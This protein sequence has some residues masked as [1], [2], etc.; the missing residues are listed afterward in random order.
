MPINN[1]LTP[2]R[3]LCDVRGASKKK[4]LEHIALRIS[5]EFPDVN[6]RELLCRFVHRER[7]GTTVL[8]SGIALPHCRSKCCPA[9]VGL[10]IK[11]NTPIDF[12]TTTHTLVDLVF[13]LVVPEE[14]TQNHINLLKQLVT[15]LQSQK[16]LHD[17]RVTSS[18]EEIYR[19]LIADC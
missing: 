16:L 18:P 5:E 3:I 17:I 14:E 9:P 13:A 10:F 15:R 6:P 4:I 1:L 11:L 2:A 12:N 19:R 8:D 7:L